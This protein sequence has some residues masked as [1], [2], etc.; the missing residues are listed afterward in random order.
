[1]LVSTERRHWMRNKAVRQVKEWWKCFRAQP[2]WMIFYLY[3]CFISGKC[4]LRCYGF[5]I[6][7][8]WPSLL[9][10][11]PTIIWKKTNFSKLWL[12]FLAI[13]SKGKLG[14]TWPNPSTTW[15]LSGFRQLFSLF[16][17]SLSYVVLIW[18]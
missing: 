4:L 10:N 18:T 12:F 3:G 15:Y 6:W 1:M 2:T 14:S 9:Y 8:M 17:L 5:H 7:L 13:S 16:G 11:F